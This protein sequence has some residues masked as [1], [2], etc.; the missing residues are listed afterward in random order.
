MRPLR[1]AP[2]ALLT[3]KQLHERRFTARQIEAMTGWKWLVRLHQG[4]YFV[5]APDVL[6]RAALMAAGEGGA[7]C[8]ESALAHLDLRLRCLGPIHVNR[9]GD[10]RKG[11]RRVKIHRARIPDSDITVVRGLR[12]TTPTRTLL[13]V[14]KSQPRYALLRALEQA[15]RLRLHAQR[16]RLDGS[17]HLI[18]PLELFDH[19]GPCTRSDAEAMFLFICEDHAIPRPLVNRMVAGRE[20]DF[21]WPDRRLV[22]EVDGHEFHDG[23]PAFRDDRRRG[24]DYARAGYELIRFAAEDVERDPVLVAETVLARLRA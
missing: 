4:V 1:A 10:R 17:P 14:A 12:T 19:Y 22:V 21:H 5:T 3:T 9:V 23:L 20:A 11:D 16:E 24:G 6:S 15:E 18:Q 2:N 7:L 13:D 8:H